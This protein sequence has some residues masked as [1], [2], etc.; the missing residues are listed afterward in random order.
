MDTSTPNINI[1]DA[2]GPAI[3]ESNLLDR[4]VGVFGVHVDLLLFDGLA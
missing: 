2:Y 1:Y 4:G 3:Y